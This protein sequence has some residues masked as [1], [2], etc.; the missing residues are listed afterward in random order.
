MLENQ[1]PPISRVRWLADPKWTPVKFLR[2]LHHLAPCARIRRLP[3]GGRCLTGRPAAA[4]SA[5]ARRSFGFPTALASTLLTRR[6]SPLL[7]AKSA[8]P[9]NAAK[10]ILLVDVRGEEVAFWRKKG[11]VRRE[12][13]SSLTGLEGEKQSCASR[14]CR[15]EDR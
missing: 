5:R 7:A 12:D 11:D 4:R 14:T 2:Q 9:L 8:A 6:S 13:V 1:R 15:A 10:L 3:R